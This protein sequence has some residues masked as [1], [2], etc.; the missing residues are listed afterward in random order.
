[1]NQQREKKFISVLALLI[2][3]QIMG[4]AGTETTDDNRREGPPSMGQNGGGGRPGGPPPLNG[5]SRSG[6]DNGHSDE[7]PVEAIEVCVGKNIGDFVEFTD[8]KGM[9]IKAT[10]QDYDDHLVAVPKETGNKKNNRM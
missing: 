6:P 5:N 7:I 9:T 2:I 1:M 8:L 3:L 4:C 10:C